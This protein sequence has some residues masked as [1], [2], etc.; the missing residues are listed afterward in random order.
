MSGT[1]DERLRCGN[2]RAEVDLATGVKVSIEREGEQLTGALCED[3]AAIE[4]RHCGGTTSIRTLLEG[5]FQLL[6]KSPLVECDR[7]EEEVS[8]RHAVE[9]Q[10]PN[11]PQYQKR[12]CEDC[13]KEITVPQ[14][15]TV[16]RDFRVE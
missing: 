12:I 11:D 13:F 2:C 4:C 7:C 3:C 1:E 10:H 15:Y 5:D 8:A 16:I 14:D 6:S 9:I